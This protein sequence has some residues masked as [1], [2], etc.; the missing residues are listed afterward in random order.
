MSDSEA[1]DLFPKPIFWP[2]SRII[3]KYQA[4]QPHILWWVWWPDPDHSS[5]HNSHSSSRNDATSVILNADITLD[6]SSIQSSSDNKAVSGP[7]GEPIGGI[8][9]FGQACPVN[10]KGRYSA[11]ILL[12]SDSR[13]LR[14]A[15]PVPPTVVST[16]P[17]GELVSS[18]EHSCKGLTY[19]YG[20]QAGQESYLQYVK[21][22]CWE[23]WAS[24]SCG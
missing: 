5:D 24:V 2:W 7:S 19:Y 14:F 15:T 8:P 22:T 17:V 6:D 9:D 16:T 20:I 13:I 23:L 12:E 4:N 10:R 1:R 18:I 3:T 21:W 11:E